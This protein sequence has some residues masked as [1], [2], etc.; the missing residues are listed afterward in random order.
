MEKLT[1]NL[2]VQAFGINYIS[3]L[4]EASFPKMAERL[5]PVSLQFNLLNL[6]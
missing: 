4:Q 2:D 3:S 6:V 1:A 5:L